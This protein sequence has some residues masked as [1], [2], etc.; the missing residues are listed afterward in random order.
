MGT[1]TVDQ[2]VEK[3][4]EAFLV[5]PDESSDVSWK[6]QLIASVRYIDIED[7]C[8]HVLFCKSLECKTTG[9]DISCVVNV[10]FCE[11]GLS[12]ESCSSVCTDGA[13]SMTDR[14]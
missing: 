10:F 8:E 1:D 9:E 13:A 12:W 7:I 4:G 11:D 3:L 5:Q 2:I 6:A 14:L